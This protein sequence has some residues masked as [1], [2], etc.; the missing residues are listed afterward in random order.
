M[1]KLKKP[2]VTELC[3][4]KWFYTETHH[5]SSPLQHMASDD[6]GRALVDIAL[7]WYKFVMYQI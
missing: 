7:Q 1:C 4:Y 3:I 6:V 2:T 5:R